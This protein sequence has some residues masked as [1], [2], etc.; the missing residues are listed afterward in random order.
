MR[1]TPTINS[2]RRAGSAPVIYQRSECY[3]NSNNNDMTRTVTMEAKERLSRQLKPITVH[4]YP[5]PVWPL[6]HLDPT[7]CTLLGSHTGVMAEEVDTRILTHYGGANS[8][9]MSEL[10]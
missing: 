3:N 8:L 5:I 6:T 2:L 1:S 9:L 7:N 4:P 10:I